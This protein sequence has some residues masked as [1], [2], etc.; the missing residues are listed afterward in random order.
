MWEPISARLVGRHEGRIGIGGT[1][2]Q[3]GHAL[4]VASADAAIL[5]SELEGQVMTR[6][7]VLHEFLVLL[8]RE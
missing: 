5:C 7:M 3:I 2:P 1:H 4:I 6:G 8:V